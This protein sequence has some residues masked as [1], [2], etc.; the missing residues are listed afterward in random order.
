M[1]TSTPMRRTVAEGRFDARRDAVVD[2]ANATCTT[3][4]RARFLPV[5]QDVETNE[6]LQE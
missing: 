4:L 5:P 2:E 3:A 6:L 1:L